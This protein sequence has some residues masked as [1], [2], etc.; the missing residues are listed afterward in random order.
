MKKLFLSIILTSVCS[1]QMV[2][3]ENKAF[4]LA[5]VFEYE[6]ALTEELKKRNPSAKEKQAIYNLAGRELYYLG[7]YDKADEYY[8]KSIDENVNVNKSEAYVNRISVQLIKKDSGLLKERVSEARKYFSQNK[9]YFSKD[10]EFYLSSM[11]EVV[12]KK[13]SNTKPGLFS[14]YTE[15]LSFKE[16]VKNKNYSELLARY[17]V[18]KLADADYMQN[19]KYDLLHVLVRKKMVSH[20]F[21]VDKIK[22]YRNSYAPSVM[23]CEMLEDYLKGNKISEEKMKRL[24]SYFEEISDTESYLLPAVKELL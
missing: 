24:E 20:L 22:D 10:M 5:K 17:D 1:A 13:V 23:I 11:D 15:Q 19:T 7:Y 3:A 18:Q 16:E 21:C 12:N 8:K 2:K 4:P 14:F 6:K 9:K